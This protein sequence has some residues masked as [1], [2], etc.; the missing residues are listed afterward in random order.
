MLVD[1]QANKLEPEGAAVHRSDPGFANPFN[2]KKISM[3]CRQ[4]SLSLMAQQ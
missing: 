1:E 3:V 4:T 2:Q